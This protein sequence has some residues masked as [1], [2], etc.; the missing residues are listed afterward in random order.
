MSISGLLVLLLAGAAGPQEVAPGL[1]FPTIEI[2]GIPD[3][4]MPG[5]YRSLLVMPEDES[6]ARTILR[7]VGVGAD[8]TVLG[9]IEYGG[10]YNPA[11]TEWNWDGGAG[12]VVV[13]SQMPGSANTFLA[14]YALASDAPFLALLSEGWIDPSRDATDEAWRLIDEGR[15]TEAILTL[16]TVFYPHNYY[17]PEEIGAAAL[18][19]SHEL[20]LELFDTGDA[21]G[22][23]STMALVIDSAG[24]FWLDPDWPAGFESRE[25]YDSSEAAVWLPFEEFIEILN[26]YGYFQLEAGNPDRASEILQGVV[27]LAPGRAVARLNLADALWALGRFGEARPHYNEYLRLLD[28]DGLLD[29]APSYSRERAR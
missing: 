16:Y 3:S 11:K 13:Y 18:H 21:A 19:R 27:R 24:I 29:H 23:C 1:A 22:A 25:G 5:G 15:L 28:D 2:Q 4:L 26:D 8:T 10:A 9:V 12:T 17:I 7:L 6:R 14:E 20:A